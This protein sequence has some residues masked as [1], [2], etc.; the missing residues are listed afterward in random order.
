[1]KKPSL[2]VALTLA[3]A[4]TLAPGASAEE[5]E[6]VSPTDNSGCTYEQESGFSNDSSFEQQWDG[7]YHAHNGFYDSSATTGESHTTDLYSGANLEAQS[8]EQNGIRWD[9][10]SDGTTTTSYTAPRP[11]CDTG[12][13]VCSATGNSNA[14]WDEYGNALG[15]SVE[16]AEWYAYQ[17]PDYVPP[18]EEPVVE[19]TEEPVETT[20]DAPQEDTTPTTNEATEEAVEASEDTTPESEETTD[21]TTDTVTGA[22]ESVAE[23]EPEASTEGAGSGEATEPAAEPTQ[24]AE[25][26]SEATITLTEEEINAYITESLDLEVPAVPNVGSAAPAGSNFVETHTLGS[27][28]AHTGSDAAA[29]LFISLVFGAT[30]IIAYFS[31]KEN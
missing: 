22:D 20:E 31:G 25:D 9:Y 23:P 1:M 2:A 26:P 27:S 10:N 17:N 6:A 14:Y 15:T 18:T 29:A 24:P 8:A 28:L 16:Y 12:E 19:P 3:A 30:G 5:G 4:L 7:N 13:W 21:D 11:Q